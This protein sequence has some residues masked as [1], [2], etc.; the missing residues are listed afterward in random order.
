MYTFGSLNV[1]YAA[2]GGGILNAQSSASFTVTNTATNTTEALSCTL[3]GG[4]TCQLNG[5]PKNP[6][7]QVWLQLNLIAYFSFLDTR[8]CDGKTASITGSA[9]MPF[10]CP[11]TP[12]ELGQTCLG[13]VEVVEANGYVDVAVEP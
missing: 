12:I 11:D 7:L 3:R 13:D 4:Y 2:S 1:T 10:T 8:A 9:E 6:D 5:T